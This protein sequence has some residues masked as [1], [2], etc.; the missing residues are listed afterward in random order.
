[1]SIEEWY[2]INRKRISILN[3]PGVYDRKEI[4]NKVLA[5]SYEMFNEMNYSVDDL[6]FVP[7][8]NLDDDQLE[9]W[10]GY[11][12]QTSLENVLFHLEKDNKGKKVEMKRKSLLGGLK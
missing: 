10:Y 9:K 8:L 5:V 6:E 3:V 2:R 4:L 7:S 12:I 11:I 1:M